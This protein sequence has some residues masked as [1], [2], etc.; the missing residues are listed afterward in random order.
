[1]SQSAGIRF[2]LCFY[3]PALHNVVLYTCSF[4]SLRN[5]VLFVYTFIFCIFGHSAI[6][7]YAFC[8]GGGP[9]AVAGNLN[10]LKPFTHTHT[11]TQNLKTHYCESKERY[12]N[13]QFSHLVVR[14]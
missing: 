14:R 4:T 8:G 1:M 6:T 9:V 12:I 5:F 10:S 13:E 7:F 3:K 11:H 2:V